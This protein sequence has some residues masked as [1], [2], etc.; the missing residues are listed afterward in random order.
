MTRKITEGQSTVDRKLLLPPSPGPGSTVSVLQF[1]G[2][3]MQEQYRTLNCA[4]PSSFL[5]SSTDEFR[6]RLSLLSRDVLLSCV[7]RFQNIPTTHRIKADFIDL[8]QSDFAQQTNRLIQFSTSEF[9]Q[10]VSPPAG[11][12]TLRFL[13]A[14]QF[15]YLASRP[16]LNP[17][18][19][20][21]PPGHSPPAPKPAVCRGR[22]DPSVSTPSQ[23]C[24]T[25]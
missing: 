19:A 23:A 11:H 7:R 22:P 1:Y 20:R 18:A 14:C 25:S 21:V 15:T 12:S 24:G 8:V 3:N 2:L 6:G 17:S 9:M 4:Y 16:T 10:C 5:S 13:L